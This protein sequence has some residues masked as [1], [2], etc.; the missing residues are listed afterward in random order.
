MIIGIASF[1]RFCAGN[2]G[3]R[4]STAVE[5]PTAGAGA[6]H[7]PWHQSFVPDLLHCK[8]VQA[9]KNSLALAYRGVPFLMAQKPLIFSAARAFLTAAIQGLALAR[10]LLF[11]LTT[12]P[13]L[14][15][16]KSFAVKPPTVFALEPRSTMTLAILPVAVLLTLFFFIAFMAFIAFIAFIA[17]AIA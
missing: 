16:V 5:I 2:W 13:Y 11:L 6:S 14:F 15:L 12:L 3:L 7:K 8:C 4:R 10:R 17:F 9:L 1:V